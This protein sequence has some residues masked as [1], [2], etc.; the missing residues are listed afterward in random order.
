MIF[1]NVFAFKW[2]K[3]QKEEIS[4]KE[5][6]REAFPIPFD[7]DYKIFQLTLFGGSHS[8]TIRRLLTRFRLKSR[9]QL[10][11]LICIPTLH[12]HSLPNFHI[13][14]GNGKHNTVRKAGTELAQWI[15][16]FAYI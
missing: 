9:H 10:R 15:P 12:P 16:K 8:R 11:R 7:S 6:L 5:T 3:A 2:T 4:K 13:T 1:E 14:N